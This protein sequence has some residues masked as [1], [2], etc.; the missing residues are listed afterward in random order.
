MC[1]RDSYQGVAPEIAVSLAGADL[2]IN[3]TVAYG[4][5]P[6]GTPVSK[7]FVIRNRGNLNLMISSVTVPAGYQ[8]AS[9]T[10]F[11]L[12][13]APGDQVRLTVQLTAS[14]AGLFK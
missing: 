11:P 8:I 7:T 5:T 3:S 13:V 6:Q 14:T 4:S 2:A 12:F 9:T 1:I 10:L